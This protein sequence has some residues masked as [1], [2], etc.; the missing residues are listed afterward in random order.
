[1]YVI[2]ARDKFM[3]A[4]AARLLRIV[5]HDPG[6]VWDDAPPGVAVRNACF[7][8][9]PSG[10]LTGVVTDAGTLS[11]DMLEEACR[12]A[13]ADASDEDIASLLG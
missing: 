9:V 3:D 1:M 4:R 7:E 11:P 6:E 13:S 8:R 12:A 2:A 10:L 5:E